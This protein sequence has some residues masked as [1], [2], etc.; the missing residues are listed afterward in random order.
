LRSAVAINMVQM[1][2]LG[3]FV[4]IPLMIAALGGSAGRVWVDRRRAARPRR[5]AGVVGARRFDAG[6]RR[7]LPLARDGLFFRPF[8]RLH[9]RH[10]FP[11]VA[12]LVMGAI[13]AVASFFTLTTVI[14]VLLAVF[15]IVQA[16]AQWLPSRCCAAAS[17]TCDAPIDSGSLRCPV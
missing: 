1:C 11:H 14:N 12:L 16:I 13:T 8:G 5:R 2:G 17:R 15:V 6:R 9:P 10:H 7:Y 3:P 4:T